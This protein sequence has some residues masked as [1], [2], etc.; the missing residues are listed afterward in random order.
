MESAA[1]IAPLTKSSSFIN[2]SPIT[3]VTRFTKTVRKY[4]KPTRRSIEY[5]KRMKSMIKNPT[6]AFEEAKKHLLPIINVLCPDCSM[7]H[8]KIEWSL[9]CQIACKRKDETDETDEDHFES[10]RGEKFYTINALRNYCCRE[11]GMVTGNENFHI[12]YNIDGYKLAPKIT[13]TTCEY[14]ERF[15]KS[16]LIYLTCKHN[17]NR[18]L[19][20]TYSDKTFSILLD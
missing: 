13:A 16:H 2:M 10:V 9:I 11:L 17:L 14:Y 1:K 18:I 7:I 20:Y 8:C 3:K 12:A 5:G 6:H 4:A 15:V 19:T